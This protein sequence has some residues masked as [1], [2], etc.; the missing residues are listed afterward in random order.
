MIYELEKLNIPAAKLYILKCIRNLKGLNQR[1]MKAR[2]V[3]Q[4]KQNLK[5]TAPRI[6]YLPQMLFWYPTFRD[7]EERHTPNSKASGIFLQ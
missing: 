3:I 7:T 5:T 1:M 2:K 6:I 4:S